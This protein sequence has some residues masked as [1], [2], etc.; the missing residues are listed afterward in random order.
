MSQ[1]QFLYTNQGRNR[2][3]VSKIIDFFKAFRSGVDFPDCMRKG[4]QVAE[5]M[6]FENPESNDVV[7]EGTDSQGNGRGDIVH[8]TDK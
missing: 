8:N 6:E 2:I 3:S 5:S 7:L 1:E 4:L